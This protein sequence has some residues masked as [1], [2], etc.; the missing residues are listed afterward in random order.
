MQQIFCGHILKAITMFEFLLMKVAVFLSCFFVF[1]GFIKM[2]V[3]YLPR[4]NPI[5]YSDYSDT[6]IIIW[7]DCI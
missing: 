4:V 6:T 3:F 2:E 7:G 5:Y 1:T